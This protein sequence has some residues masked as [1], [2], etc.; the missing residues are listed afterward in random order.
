MRDPAYKGGCWPGWTLELDTRAIPGPKSPGRGITTVY[1]GYD[2]L[3]S[4]KVPFSLFGLQ[5]RSPEPP[6]LIEFE[7]TIS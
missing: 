5:V 2:K 7:F 1:D 6:R 3:F 4:I